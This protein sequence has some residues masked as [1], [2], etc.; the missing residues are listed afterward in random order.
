MKLI[1]FNFDTCIFEYK[2]DKLLKGFFDLFLKEDAP[3]YLK[4][5]K[6]LLLTNKDYES[7]RSLLD[8][9]PEIKYTWLQCKAYYR[10]SFIK[11]YLSNHPAEEVVAFGSSEKDANIYASH[12]I[13]F[14]LVNI[15]EGYEPYEEILKSF[16][17]NTT[18]RNNYLYDYKTSPANKGMNIPF[19]ENVIYYKC[20]LDTRRYDHSNKLVGCS[21]APDIDG[22][23]ALK[24]FTQAE[25]GQT[26]KHENILNHL[27]EFANLFS[28]LPIDNQTILVRVPGHDEVVYRD[29]PLSKMLARIVENHHAGV[30]GSC[31]LHR[32]KPAVASKEEQRSV[33]K[34]T[35]TVEVIPEAR[36][37]IPGRTI[38]LFDDICTSGTSLLACSHI[39]RQAGAK[40]VICFVIA[41]TCTIGKI[42]PEEI[43]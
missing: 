42:A 9:Y 36:K 28:D 32:S 10:K 2:S 18:W 7:S 4:S 6:V 16:S 22:R 23:K 38:Y 37:L 25:F 29:S 8:K 33:L 11:K 5:H 27:N 17:K 35:S 40:E 13:P 31:F 21:F 41:H 19:I 34:H 43:K 3:L 15:L 24:T 30:N 20:Y 1:I 12:N 39:L 26:K 14:Y